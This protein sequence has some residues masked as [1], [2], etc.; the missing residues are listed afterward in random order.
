MVGIAL[1]NARGDGCD[2]VIVLEGGIVTGI[3]GR[4]V[5][6]DGGRELGVDAEVTCTEAGPA[7]EDV[8]VVECNSG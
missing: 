3:V 8:A 7:V 2:A 4:A 5:V 6:V 1:I